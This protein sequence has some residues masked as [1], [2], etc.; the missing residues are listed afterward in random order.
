[1]AASQGQL[2]M[3]A[4]YLEG[5]RPTHL[6]IDEDTQEQTREWYMHCPLHRDSKRSGSLN[7]DKEVYNCQVCGGM[8][9]STLMKRQSEWLTYNGN[10][11]A[12]GKVL[13]LDAG[14]AKPIRQLSEGMIAGWH[15]SLLSNP[16]S[17]A[18]LEEERGIK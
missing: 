15:S 17:L 10:G 18:W 14:V 11:H 2:K 16:R 1:M 13:H 6:N 5:D 9:L 8:S 3:L 4:P 7:L 12:S